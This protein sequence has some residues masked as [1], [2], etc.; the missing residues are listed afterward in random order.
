MTKTIQHLRGTTAQNDAFTGAAGEITVDTTTNELRLHD[1]STAGGHIIPNKAECQ[2]LLGGGTAGTLL[3]NSGTPG[4]VNTTSID[5]TPTDGSDNPVSS[6]GVY[7]ALATKASTDLDNLTNTGANI[8]HWSTNVTNCITYIPQDI[9]LEVS[10]S[11][12]VLKAGSKCY[13]PD[14]TYDTVATDSSITASNNAD[15]ILYYDGN[16]GLGWAQKSECYSQPTAPTATQYMLWWDTANNVMKHTHDTGSTWQT[17]GLPVGSF[18]AGATQITQLS[19]TFNGFGFMGPV[20]FMLPGVK[21]L[22]PNGRNADGSLKNI[23]WEADTVYKT[24]Y[25]NW[26]STSDQYVQMGPSV[27]NIWSRYVQ[28]E[29]MPSTNDYTLWYKPS[30]NILR[31]NN[32]A[33]SYTS[34]DQWTITTGGIYVTNVGPGTNIDAIYYKQPGVCHVLDYTNTEYMCN[35]AMPSGVAISLTPTNNADYIA[36]ADGWFVAI[37]SG[38]GTN[39]WLELVSDTAQGVYGTV[40][41]QYKVSLAIKK[42]AVCKLNFNDINFATFKFVYANGAIGWK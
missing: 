20:V 3:T 12:I 6:N 5:A 31:L 23:E 2:G 14:G 7:D 26:V 35:Q 33:N 25:R 18:T 38:T 32:T 4:T 17:V 24:N 39:M 34:E 29:Y 15:G 1:G 36:P 28:T 10:G 9:K 8:G 22:I 30:E 42:G 19:R 16:G 11:A 41:W 37:G 21:M 27:N 13:Y 40:G